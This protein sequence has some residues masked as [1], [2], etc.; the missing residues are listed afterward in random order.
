MT[1]VPA[2]LWSERVSGGIHSEVPGTMAQG[3][4]AVSSDPEDLLLQD[5][6]I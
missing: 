6:D 2:R 3:C 1:R 4:D 5:I